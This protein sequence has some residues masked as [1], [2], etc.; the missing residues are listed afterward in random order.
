MRRLQTILVAAPGAELRRSLAF[1]LDA[2]GF[3]VVSHRSLRAALESAGGAAGVVVDENALSDGTKD[4]AALKRFG[5]PVIL[6]V[7]RMRV[8]PRIDGLRVLDK[9]LLGRLLIETVQSALTEGA[10]EPS[11]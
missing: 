6:L 8:L 5:R 7:D 11:T 4:V 1:A 2:D 10:T 9:P 3:D